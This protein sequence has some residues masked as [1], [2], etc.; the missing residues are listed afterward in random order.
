MP[1]LIMNLHGDYMKKF[2]C[3]FVVLA[4]IA[5][6]LFASCSVNDSEEYVSSSQN[7][8]FIPFQ[9]AIDEEVFDAGLVINTCFFTED[10]KDEIANCDKIV[11]A[12]LITADTEIP[13]TVLESY[14]SDE[15]INVNNRDFYSGYLTFEID[16]FIEINEGVVTMNVEFKGGEVEEYLIGEMI[17][18]RTINSDENKIEVAMIYPVPCMDDN[19]LLLIND[20]FIVCVASE[21]IKINEINFGFED[22]GIDSDNIEVF[23]AEE[24]ETLIADSVDNLALDSIIDGAYE[25]RVK[26]SVSECEI[27]LEKGM[28]YIYL[29][30]TQGTDEQI[31]PI[32][33][34]A[35]IKYNDV[36]GEKE[37]FTTS[38]VLYSLGNPGEA[39]VQKYME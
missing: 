27:D 30:L 8:V 14:I 1:S 13:I 26:P 11:N 28:H 19:G 6:C 35:N 21:P 3:I 23:S 25:E 36:Q 5:V 12:S 18:E 33:M 38:F 9:Y 31:E 15:S 16:E 10:A 39:L 7:A 24:F 4:M 20:L 37:Y 2:S 22:I 29:P 32:R 34:I 17:I